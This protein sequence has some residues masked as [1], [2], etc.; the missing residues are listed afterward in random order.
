M[1]LKNMCM[2]TNERGDLKKTASSSDRNTEWKKK[3]EEK[4]PKHYR[5]SRAHFIRIDFQWF[6]VSFF[7][8]FLFYFFITHSFTNTHF[9]WVVLLFQLSKIRRASIT[10]YLYIHKN[11][12]QPPSSTK[13]RRRRRRK[14]TNR[15]GFG[16]FSSFSPEL[17]WWW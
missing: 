16:V 7:F 9:N 12:L 17:R 11:E 1:Y 13:E 3:R 4:R 10:K 14:M 8:S 6:S 15:N 5:A 2:N